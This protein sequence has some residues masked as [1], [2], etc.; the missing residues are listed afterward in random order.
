MIVKFRKLHLSY[1]EKTNSYE[2]PETCFSETLIK[3][4]RI[5][6]NYLFYFIEDGE[7]EFV[8]IKRKGKYLLCEDSDNL[9]LSEKPLKELKKYIKEFNRKYKEN[10]EIIIFLSNN[11]EIIKEEKIE[12]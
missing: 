11:R 7:K 2:E 3:Q 5:I 10:Y 4:K 9:I 6:G 12:I 1:N 8:S